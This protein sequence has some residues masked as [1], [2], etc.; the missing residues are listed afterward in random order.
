MF[1]HFTFS[2]TLHDE[3]ADA[4]PAIADVP[5]RIDVAQHLMPD[6]ASN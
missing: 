6:W 1:R 5:G 3:E 2:V 4:L